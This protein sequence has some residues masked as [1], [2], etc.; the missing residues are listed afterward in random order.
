MMGRFQ[1]ARVGDVRVLLIEDA[2]GASVVA[3]GLIVEA[4]Q[5][6][7]S[8][9]GRA[10]IGLATGSTPVKAYGLVAER[11]RSG[12]LSFRDVTTYNLDEYYPISPLNPLSY[13]YYMNEHLF[14]HIDLAPDR[15]H[16]PDG[17]VPEAFVDE[18]CKQYDRWI[19]AEGGLDLQLLGIGRN[20][21]IGFNEPTDLTVGQA[22]ELPTRLVVLHEVTRADAVR[23]FGSVEAVI[24]QALTMGIKTI[25]AA[26]SILMLATGA[27]KA[28]AVARALLEPMTANVPA[29]LLRTAGDR[30][31]WIVDLEAASGL[32]P[33]LDLRALV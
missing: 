5:N 27:A 12:T 22:I 26:R 14:R 11:Y 32:G 1:E 17:T 8:A 25:L 6:A 3:A 13:R 23:E 9:R 33:A 10:V 4:I 7:K 24:P 21:H 16:L 20:G 15:A 30:V 29:S 31:T 18:Y 28:K 19:E 2:I